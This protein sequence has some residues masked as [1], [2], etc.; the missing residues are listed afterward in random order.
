MFNGASLISLDSVGEIGSGHRSVV[1]FVEF[2]HQRI[3]GLVEFGHRSVVG[4]GG[5]GFGEVEEKI[6]GIRCLII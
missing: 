3:V 6:L 4:H 1:G 5:Y 2:G